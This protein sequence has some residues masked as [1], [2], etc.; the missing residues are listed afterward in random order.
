MFSACMHFGIE[1]PLPVSFLKPTPFSNRISERDS[2]SG[3]AGTYSL[4]IEIIRFLH[5]PKRGLMA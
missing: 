1:L 4:A 5:T 2:M 3:M